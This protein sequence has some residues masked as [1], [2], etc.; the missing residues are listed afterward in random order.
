MTAHIGFPT[1]RILRVG[2]GSLTLGQLRL[3]PG[4]CR[5]L[6]AEEV[7]RSIHEDIERRRFG[8]TNCYRI[9][10]VHF[11]LHLRA[12]TIFSDRMQRSLF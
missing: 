12:L 11:L 8:G 4:G 9:D 7:L 6:T 5:Q 1:L 3:K 10:L 2:I